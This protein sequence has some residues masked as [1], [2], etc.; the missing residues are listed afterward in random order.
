METTASPSPTIPSRLE[1][2]TVEE[3]ER[4]SRLAS[5]V[6]AVTFQRLIEDASR[7]WTLEEELVL[8][9]LRRSTGSLRTASAQELSDYLGSL[10]QDQLR[11]VASNVK[12]IYHEL[13]FVQA[14][15]GDW[16]SV[17]AEV[18]EFTNHPGGDVEFIVDGNVIGEVQL[19]AVAS[20]AQ[21]LEHLARYPDIEIRVTDEVAAK[22]PGI[23]SSGF[24]NTELTRDVY[25]RLAV[26]QGDGLV[27]EI[28]EGLATSSLVSSAIIAGK[29]VRGRHLSGTQIRSFLV[30]AG[31]GASTAAVLDVLLLPL[32][33]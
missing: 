28:S 5:V 4:H 23:E 32:T 13:L 3:S 20:E 27:D 12:G 15:N 30:D 2:R 33:S 21:V 14:E 25:D 16:D 24:S 19:K 6:I 22:M 26:L 31:I 7:E 29:A 18:K 11:G 8:Q 10:S 9:A 1:T 17:A